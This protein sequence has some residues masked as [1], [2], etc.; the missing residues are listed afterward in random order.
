M[1]L[2]SKVLFDDGDFS[3]HGGDEF[4]PIK[5]WFDFRGK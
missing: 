3:S 2:F 5:L 1:M 4:Y